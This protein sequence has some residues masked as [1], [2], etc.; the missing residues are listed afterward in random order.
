MLLKLFKSTSQTPGLSAEQ[1]AVE[2]ARSAPL[3][4]SAKTDDINYQL[5]L[6]AS[7]ETAH[8]RNLIGVGLRRHVVKVSV[9]ILNYQPANLTG[10]PNGTT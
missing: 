9:Q 4:Q 3:V 2:W 5:S 6:L 7:G 1:I 8:T 10:E